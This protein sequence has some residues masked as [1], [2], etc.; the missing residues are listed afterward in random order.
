[1]YKVL[2][3]SY[4]LKKLSHGILSYFDHVQNII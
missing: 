4:D 1:M 3:A 2:I